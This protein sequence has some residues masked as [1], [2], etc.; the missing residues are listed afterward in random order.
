[1]TL[2][3]TPAQLARAKES[4]DFWRAKKA[5]EMQVFALLG[6]EAGETGFIWKVDSDGK[7][8]TP[9][10]D[11]GRARG[12][13]QHWPARGEIILAKCGKDV[14]FGGHLE[15]LEGA[16]QEMTAVWS[17]YRHVW[18]DLVAAKTAWACEQELVKAYEQSKSQGPDTVKR[19]ALAVYLQH[20]IGATA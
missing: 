20:K 19:V 8:F 6:C 9:A 2:F 18:R 12:P 1:M 16:Y 11:G 17:A 7:E 14:R 13:F 5:A 3:M 15:A 10:G 4:R